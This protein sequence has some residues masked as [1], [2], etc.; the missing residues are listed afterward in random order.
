MNNSRI[1]ELIVSGNN[2]HGVYLYG[3]GTGQC[4]GNII[5]DCTISENEGYGVYL[6]S[7]GGRDGLFLL[8]R[9]H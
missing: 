5:S 1:K 3:G 9:S 7:V 6:D 4:D 8:P 2:S